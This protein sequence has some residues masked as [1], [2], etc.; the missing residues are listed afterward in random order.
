MNNDKDMILA[1]IEAGALLDFRVADK[2]HWKTPLHY[3]AANNKVTAI[4]V[5]KI[6]FFFKKCFV[7]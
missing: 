7:A 4:Q 3:A 6:L 2:D 5:T 1:L